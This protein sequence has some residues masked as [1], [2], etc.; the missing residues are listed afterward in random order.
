MAV[1]SAARPPR[2]APDVDVRGALVEFYQTFAPHK[3]GDI[4]RVLQHFDGRVNDLIETL[5]VK[6][7]V[8]F[9]ERGRA[10]PAA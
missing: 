3:L 8:K 2:L 1:G 6:Y 5:E 10:S 9:D 4:D 7:K